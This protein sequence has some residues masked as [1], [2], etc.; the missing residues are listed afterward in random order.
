MPD[1]IYVYIDGESHFHRS[2]CA[3]QGIH[4]SEASLEQVRY[5]REPA[6][7]VFV[8]SKAK[9]FWTR[10]LSPGAD[11]AYYFSSTFG[12]PAAH[13]D[14]QKRLRQFGLES[15]I[16][17][18]HKSHW[19]QRQ[20]QRTTQKLIEKAKGV[21]I[22]LTVRMLEDAQAGLFEECHLYT[23][24]IDFLPAINAVRGRGKRVYVF[25]YAE[26][27]S[28]QSPFLHACEQFVDLEELMRNECELYPPKEIA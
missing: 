19:D 2:E 4:G 15:Q 26:G 5:V 13:H 21:D 27:L 18:E 8:E 9:V 16:V 6:D 20:H 24:D 12:D 28:K 23:S 14:I 11:R 25:G 22:A 17:L 3:W 7:L 1:R 10:R